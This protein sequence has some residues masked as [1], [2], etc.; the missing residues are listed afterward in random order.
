MKAILVV[1]ALVLAGAAGVAFGQQATSSFVREQLEEAADKDSQAIIGEL[2]SGQLKES[3]QQSFTFDVDPGKTYTVYG[4]CDEDCSDLFLR[5]SETGGG[6]FID[7]SSG[8]NNDHPKV[9][10]EDFKGDQITIEA[11]MFGCNDE[12]CE[13]GVALAEAGKLSASALS[14]TL[15][16]GDLFSGAFS[17]KSD[18]K[19]DSADDEPASAPLSQEARA[20]LVAALRKR[21][22]D[23]FEQSDDILSEKLKSGEHVQWQYE[24]DPG[25]IREI[26]AICDA[27]GNLDLF[28]YDE[29]G[30]KLDSD[31]DSDNKP[32]LEITSDSWPRE[33]RSG[34]QKLIVDV[35]MISCSKNA[36]GYSV[37]TF[38]PK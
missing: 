8:Q 1:S 15:T 24:V 35:R 33:R 16:L 11:K 2:K 28:V 17:E 18:R 36:C 6:D 20:E 10:I 23:F 14:R 4:A 34:K 27:C 26:Y 12:P 13:F 5:A 25:G 37:G 32:A 21:V 19:A 9:E 29:D 7:N 22:P 3:E 31:T 30:D 38:K